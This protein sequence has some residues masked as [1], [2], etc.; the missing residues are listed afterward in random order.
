MFFSFMLHPARQQFPVGRHVSFAHLYIFGEWLSLVSI[1]N[2]QFFIC[3]GFKDLQMLYVGFS[4]PLFYPRSTERNLEKIGLLSPILMP[5]LLPALLSLVGLLPV[6]LFAATC[7][8][9]HH[10]Y[11]Q[12][13]EAGAAPA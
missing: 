7:G 12:Q 2:R 8:S 11:T 3:T 4:R 5:G 9:D 13:R 10:A 6:T 1:D